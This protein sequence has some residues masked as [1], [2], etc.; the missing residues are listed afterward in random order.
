MNNRSFI[1]AAA[2]AVAMISCQKEI[3]RTDF[4]LSDKEA[5]ATLSLSIRQ[6]AAPATRS[7]D[8]YTDMQDYEKSINS[9]QIFVFG[10]DGGINFYKDCGTAVE[11]IELSTTTGT[12]TVYA[13]VNA[14]SLSTI[15]T[16]TELEGTAAELGASNST[17]KTKGFIMSGSET[18]DLGTTGA[19]A[20]ITVKRLT[21]RIALRKVT[22]SLPAAYGSMEITSAFLSNVVGN[23]NIA[24]NAAVSLWYN[25][26]GRKDEDTMQASHILDG[27]SYKASCPDLT[28]KALSESVSTSG[29]L[30]P[31][32]PYLFYCYP[33]SSTSTDAGFSS[34]FTAR[35]TRL[36]V[37]AVIDGITYYYPVSIE[38]PARNTSY[39]V[40][41]VITGLGSTDPD[42]PVEKGTV[43]ASIIVDSW[44]E[45]A[46]YEEII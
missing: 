44:A 11:D 37:S 24:G 29:S 26:M 27:S 3:T 25:K 16:K 32:I 4:S 41:I 35:M 34:T 14:P 38:S 17:E 40:D 12:K 10:A 13:V 21:S 33:N 28:W 23:Q 45:G 1:L 6:A 22:N 19:E 39:T 8:A 7:S 36:T 43:T 5:E 42:K 9:V 31:S 20:E 18:V 46:V 15:K 30:T 2:A